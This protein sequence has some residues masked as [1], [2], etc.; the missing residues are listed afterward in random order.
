MKTQI[1]S[2]STNPTARPFDRLDLALKIRQ[3]RGKRRDLMLEDILEWLSK[4]LV[5]SA[6]AR[7]PE[8]TGMIALT[9]ELVE[10]TA[11][12]CGRCGTIFWQSH[13]CHWRPAKKGSNGTDPLLPLLKVVLGKKLPEG[14][15]LMELRIPVSPDREVVLRNI[16]AA[17]VMSEG[18]VQ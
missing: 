9:K 17:E 1:S 11:K 6:V 4:E 2:G 15:R 13:T 3:S 7:D 8:Q 12:C 14:V 10:D 18:G 5:L 16:D